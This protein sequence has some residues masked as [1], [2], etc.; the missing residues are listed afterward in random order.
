MASVR[1]QRSRTGGFTLLEV[2]IAVLVMSIGLLGV[3]TLQFTSLKGAQDAYVR[4]QAAFLAYGITDSMRVN[5]PAARTGQYDVALDGSFS[6]VAVNCVGETANCTPAQL[7]VFDL[8]QWKQDLGQSL[9]EGNG[10]IVTDVD[11]ITGVATVIV[12]VWWKSMQGS[13]EDQSLVVEL[14]I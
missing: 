14:D 9:V 12:S 4:S 6:S 5:L 8:K 10:S 2:L 11:P 13:G 7:A 3:G 1:T